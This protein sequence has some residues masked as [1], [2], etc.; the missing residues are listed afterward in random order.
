MGVQNVVTKSRHYIQY[1][2]YT[3]LHFD[4]N[5]NGAKLGKCNLEYVWVFMVPDDYIASIDP[6]LFQGR[7]V[8]FNRQPPNH[9]DGKDPKLAWNPLATAGSYTEGRLRIRRLGLRVWFGGGAC[10]FLHGAILHH[11]IEPFSGGQRI[12]I[13]HFCHQSLWKEMGVVLR[14]SW[15]TEESVES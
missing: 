5:C 6:L 9:V 7:S 12:F 15:I 13:A 3:H 10:V 4:V 14:S 2:A 1:Q 11:E 8:I